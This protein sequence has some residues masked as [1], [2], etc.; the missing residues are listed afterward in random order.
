MPVWGLAA[1][2][3]VGAV[4]GWI[5]R[6]LRG[7]KE[8]EQAEKRGEERERAKN[9][10]R[11]ARIQS[12]L[13][14]VKDFANFGDQLVAMFAVGI[15]CANCDG[16]VHPH[17]REEIEEFIAGASHN[18][19]PSRIKESI[20]NLWNT[21]PNVKTAFQLATDAEVDS[22][23]LDDIIDLVIDVNPKARDFRNAWTKLKAA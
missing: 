2:G 4:V 23:V 7:R 11:Y 16:Q 1:A 14:D 22:L 6:T 9:V 5:A 8:K 21:P 13:E 3:L 20:D 19:L 18:S 17:E 15:A 10:E 12:Y